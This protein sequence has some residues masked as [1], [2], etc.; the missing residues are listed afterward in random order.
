MGEGSI[1]LQ[2]YIYQNF[3]THSF[4][5]DDLLPSFIAQ[6]LMFIIGS[7]SNL[8]SIVCMHIEIHYV[9]Q[10]LYLLRNS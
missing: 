1:Q 10:L 7:V 9:S 5:L 4:V 2:K 8:H 6:P 3:Y